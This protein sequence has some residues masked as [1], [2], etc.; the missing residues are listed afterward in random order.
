M[1]K[2]D[3]YVQPWWWRFWPVFVEWFNYTHIM[4]KT[5]YWEIGWIIAIVSCHQNG[6]I[7]VDAKKVRCVANTFNLILCKCRQSWPRESLLFTVRFN[8][9][10]HHLWVVAIFGEY[11]MSKPTQ[12]FWIWNEYKLIRWVPFSCIVCKTRGNLEKVSWEQL[13]KSSIKN[14][15]LPYRGTNYLKTVLT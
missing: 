15:L 5:R 13:T 14:I 9:I 1:A 7:R 4:I 3:T 8:A 10:D 6:C 12:L 2:K 11:R